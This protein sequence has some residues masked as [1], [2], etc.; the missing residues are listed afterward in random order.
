MSRIAAIESLVDRGTWQID[1][2]SW[3]TLTS[4]KAYIGGRFYSDKMPLLNLLGAG[5]YGLL[6]WGWNA[7]LAVDCAESGK[8]CAYYPLTLTLIGLPGAVLVWLFFQFLRKQQVALGSAVAVTG[9]L[10]F[11]AAVWPYCLVINH[12]LPSAAA[13]FASFYLLQTPRG[14]W[15]LVCAGIFAA[16]AVAFDMVSV[17]M[18]AGLMAT[19]MVYGL[20][21]IRY[22]ALGAIVPVLITAVLDYQITGT[23]APPYMIPG[24]Y[25]FPGSKFA[26]TAGGVAPSA[27]L[28]HYGFGMLVGERGLY[29]YSPVLLFALAGL[30]IVMF[31]PG[32]ILR[33]EAACL[34]GAYL[35]LTVYLTTGTYNFGGVAYGSRLYLHAVPLVMVF[36]A[37]VSPPT[38]SK[39]RFAVAPVFAV[40]MAISIASG[41]Q[42]AQHPWRHSPPLVHLTR[43]PETGAIGWWWNDSVFR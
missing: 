18:F 1:E 8:P 3:V 25:A 10:T 26:D 19:T 22:F 28:L 7:S 29:A 34:G 41:Y 2:S 43:N 15:R 32:R 27:D 39:W 37:F 11:G 5:V 14:W 21:A 40:L 13:L 33:W 6:H 42:G 23:I 36:A 4:D 24:A 20:H 16:S 31:T 35:A 12:H 38:P 17:F 9:A 30:G